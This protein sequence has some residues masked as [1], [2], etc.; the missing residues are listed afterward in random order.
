MS[1]TRTISGWAADLSFDQIP[2]RIIDRN[3][4]QIMSVL[5]AVYAGYGHPASQRVYRVVSADNGGPATLLPGGERVLTASALWAHAAFGV[6]HDFDDYLFAGHTGHSSVLASLAF[7]EREESSGT[8]FL[9]SQTIVNELGGRLGASMLFGPQNGQ[10]WS[11]IHN[12][13][14]AVAGA[15]LMGLDADGITRAVGIAFLQP[16]YALSPSFFGGESKSLIAAEPAA[17]G[18]RAADLAREGMTAGEDALG[19]R[20]GFLHR[21]AG[22]PLDWI[23]SGLGD[24]WVSDSLT[25]KVV[26]G[27]A[28]IDG[29]VDCLTEV[30]SA[31][32]EKLGRP[33]EADDVAKVRVW[34]S[35]LTVGMEMLCAL[36]RDRDR[37]TTVGCN[38]SVPLSLAVMLLAGELVPEALSEW[39]FDR[40]RERIIDLADRITL[41][42]DPALTSRLGALDQVGIDLGAAIAGVDPSKL[43]RL[44]E[45]MIAFSGGRPERSPAEVAEVPS[46]DGRSFEG[47]EM[48]IPARLELETTGGEVFTAE[49]EIPKGASGRPFDETSEMVRNK[50]LRNAGH[51]LGERQAEEALQ[52][53]DRLDEISSTGELIPLLVKRGR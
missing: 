24:A 12:L 16:P 38:F 32:Q 44:G 4:L 53:I 45:A 15:R 42:H 17:T 41:E 36:Y 51:H 7:G 40:N 25:Y 31:F 6:V 50:F 43:G 18:A 22:H 10:M 29:A 30:K 11:Y 20:Q 19:D 2:P 13:G 9:T 5:G 28:Y 39:F 33:L 47:F 26:P 46:L 48:R 8:D 37:L 14:S 34:G 1:L 27:C 35:V 49:V 52:T 23:F 3:K 21:F